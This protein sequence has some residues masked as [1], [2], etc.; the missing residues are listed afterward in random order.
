MGKAPAVVLSTWPFADGFPWD[1]ELIRSGHRAVSTH[2][3][4]RHRKLK[5]LRLH[6]DRAAR[7]AALER[8]AGNA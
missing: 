5:P 8:T 1:D 6:R 2:G 3:L 7:Q 4:S